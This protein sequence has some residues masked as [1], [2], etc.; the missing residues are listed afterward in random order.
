[1]QE[2]AGFLY[3]VKTRRFHFSSIASEA[4][5]SNFVILTMLRGQ[6]VLPETIQPKN[7]SKYISSFLLATLVSNQNEAFFSNFLDY[8]HCGIECR[9]FWYLTTKCTFVIVLQCI[10]PRHIFQLHQQIRLYFQS[11]KM[12]PHQLSRSLSSLK[13]LS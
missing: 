13:N 10:K 11:H 12:M 2:K 4:S 5:N 9:L 3:S 6:T 7:H 1:M 8:L